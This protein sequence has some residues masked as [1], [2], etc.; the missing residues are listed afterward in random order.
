MKRW[1]GV[2]VFRYYQTIEVDA[3]TQ[4]DAERIMFEMFDLA[5]AD[6]ESEMYDIEEVKE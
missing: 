2:V 1:K 4:D 6:G 5:K 3:P